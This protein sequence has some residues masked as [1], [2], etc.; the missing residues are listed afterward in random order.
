MLDATIIRTHNS[1]GGRSNSN[2]HYKIGRLSD[3]FAT[4]INTAYDGLGNPVKHLLAPGQTHGL[5]QAAS[6]L[7]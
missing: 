2:E 5:T 6:R 4:K 3:E 1:G 7:E